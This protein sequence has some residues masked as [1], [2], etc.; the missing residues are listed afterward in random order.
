M[1]TT[2]EI[3]VTPLMGGLSD[4]GVCSLLELGGLRVLLDCGCT[5]TSSNEELLAI[6]SKLK[7]GGGIDCVVLSHADIHHIGALPIIFGSQGLPPVP[8][9]CTLP[10]AKFSVLLL[11]DLH[12]NM[13][14]EG[15][16][17]NASI[18]ENKLEQRRPTFTLDDVDSC[19]SR[20]LSLK[21][22]QV[23][24][25]PCHVRSTVTDAANGT[26][27][28]VGSN[29]SG[30][31]VVAFCASSTGRTLGGAAWKITH[32]ATSLLYAM[33]LNLKKEVVLE[34]ARLEAL[35]QAPEL[36]VVEG[37]CASRSAA[38]R[39]SKRT[40]A[41]T[42]KEGEGAGGDG[43]AGEDA[44]LIALVN[45]TLRNRGNVLIPCE[46]CARVL[47]ALQLLSRHWIDSRKGLDH[48][49][50]LSPMSVNL[51]E[52]ARS[53]LEWMTDSIC[54][55]FYNGAANPFELPPVKVC[56]TLREV[57]RLY[58]G[59]KVVLATDANL[60]C[61]MA[62]ELL[63]RWGGNPLNRVIFL[64]VPDTGTLGSDILEKVHSPPVVL[65][66]SQA[67]RVELE[68]QE[69]AAFNSAQ[70]ERRRIKEEAMQKRVREEEI[71][72][73][74]V[75]AKGSTGT[76]DTDVELEDSDVDMNTSMLTTSSVRGGSLGPP[77]AKK[78]KQ[79]DG[80]P[81]P[82]LGQAAR[83][84]KFAQ[85]LFPIFDTREQILPADPVFGVSLDD[86][87]LRLE[88]GE[89][90]AAANAASSTS[91]TMVGVFSTTLGYSSS[92]GAPAEQESEL[93]ALP[94]KIISTR[95]RVTF[96]CDFKIVSLGGR[97]DARAIKAT[98]MKVQPNRILV[99][100]GKEEDCESMAK[101]ARAMGA[102]SGGTREG[103]GTAEVFSPANG[104]TVSFTVRTDRLYLYIPP[105]LLPASIKELTST[106][107]GESGRITHTT[108]LSAISGEA[109]EHALGSG[110]GLRKV[111]LVSTIT[112]TAVEAG[113]SAVVK[114]E[115]GEGEDEEEEVEVDEFGFRSNANTDKEAILACYAP[116]PS[117]RANVAVSVGE[118]SFNALKAALIN[119][120][121]A[122]ESVTATSADGTVGT[123]LVCEAQVLI[124][125]VGENDF[126]VEGP[127]VAA[128]WAAR[129]VLYSQF[130][131]LQ[132]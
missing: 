31:R 64:D 116:L 65:R 11:Y 83:I 130:A 100:R 49:I 123:L 125:R 95:S 32:G 40:A 112:D 17:N 26:E 5:L 98:L 115:G 126:E 23:C 94:F 16:P 81:V 104:Q 72:A 37:G 66:V 105:S 77:S 84:A 22:S 99:I 118:V 12:L 101:Q 120:G 34:G 35:P 20:R 33:D 46:S 124:R 78:Q 69:L 30:T 67:Q 79:G 6:A 55:K 53:Q 110:G 109:Q 80:T 89:A 4:G 107:E 54:T 70:E 10:V 103:G 127:P 60:Q 38:K 111:R 117:R 19:L 50:F 63:L 129:K 18:E 113:A 96:T 57:E 132:S 47:E 76:G 52:L 85:P 44:G 21:Y 86:L 73:L 108:V 25:I 48:L 41:G 56:T 29:G 119:S 87:N 74:T 9:I 62:K 131:F 14:M 91:S 2:A 27:L 71:N 15:T 58:P 1:S 92:R 8:V 97:A 39:K 3:R 102:S 45:E 36:M 59:P 68:G 24:N 28:Q 114:S 51:L 42:E 90:T 13:A 61:G 121:I 122:T 75:H 7:E 43:K 88:E 82:V 93:E 106:R 128:Y